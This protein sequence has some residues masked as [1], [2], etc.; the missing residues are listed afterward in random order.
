MRLSLLVPI[1][2]ALTLGL[3]SCASGPK[4]AE[5]AARIPEVPLG[6]GRIFFYRPSALGAAVQPDVRLNDEVV[7]EALAHGFFFVDRPPGDYVVACSTEEEHHLSFTLEP[8]QVRYVKLVI[9]F[10][11]FMGHVMPE[12]VDEQTGAAGVADST[13][14]G[15]DRDLL[16][17]PLPQ[18]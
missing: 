8:K 6:Q 4:Y 17:S 11:F 1:L 12:L 9:T 3:S 15:P 18:T 10:G 2:A 13:Y 14:T 5:V 16:S 7:G